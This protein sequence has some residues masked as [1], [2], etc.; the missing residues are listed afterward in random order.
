[1][2]WW[3]GVDVK[4][5]SNK[6]VNVKTLVNALNDMVEPPPRDLKGKLRMP[7]SGVYKIKG[8]GDV[9]TGRVEQGAVKPGD[10]VVFIPTHTAANACA[11]K[12]FTVEMH[13]KNVP[14]A[15]NGDNVGLNVKGL[16]KGNMPKVG[17]VMIVSGDNSI[18]AV[19]LFDCAVQVLDHPGDIKVGYSPVGYVRTGRSAVRLHEIK[20]NM[21]KETNNA[22]QMAPIA[23]KAAQM[24]EVVFA[25]QQPF[26][27]DSFKNC[28]GL[29]RI[30]IMEGNGVVMLGKILSVTHGAVIEVDKKAVVK[31]GAAK[32]EG[33]AEK[34]KKEAGAKKEGGAKPAGEKKPAAAK[35]A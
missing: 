13:H 10:E 31:E 17:D 26:V 14:Q 16:D 18:Q 24:G 32:K 3:K 27:C 6:V 7:V 20:W 22:K 25:P 29:G 4:T 19:S 34:P 8:V 12:V 35:K 23:L 5:V 33:G 1:M 11:G 15:G 2:P 30:A 28:A 21:G 9:I